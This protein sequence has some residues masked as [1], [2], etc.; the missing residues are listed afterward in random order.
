[1][2]C[3]A[4]SSC[5]ARTGPS[6][7]VPV[8]ALVKDQGAARALGVNHA[9]VL[10]RVN[11]FEAAAGVSLFDR[12]A[13][14]YRVAPRRRQVIAAM[15]AM[16]QA[17]L[18]VARALD[19]ARAPL[20]GTVRVTST[21]TLCLTLLPP[22]VAQMM[23]EVEGLQIE[24]NALNL[25]ADLARLD[26]DIAVRPA[27]AL[28]EGLVGAPVGRL[29]FAAYAAPGGGAGWLGLGPAL[30]RSAP[31]AWMA[32][33]LSDDDLCGR[34]D[35]FP[36]LCEMAAAGQGRTILP[37]VLG[38]ADPRLVRLEGLVPEMSIKVWVASHVDLAEVPRIRAVRDML[39]RALAGGPGLLP[40]AP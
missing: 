25:R 5:C 8:L 2:S 38:D 35:S 37:T 32:E 31:A 23:A 39:A 3:P 19:A 27:L 6:G 1:M 20:V 28:P 40:L 4:R 12:T 29:G 17:A 24:L 10:R 7:E 18:G 26:A 9:T 34:A 22:I 13:R 16:D 30:E 21:D 14:G 36:V 11:G 15:E 33:N